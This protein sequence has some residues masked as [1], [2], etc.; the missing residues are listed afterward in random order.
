MNMTQLSSSRTYERL[1]QTG[2]PVNTPIDEVGYVTGIEEYGVFVRI[3][4]HGRFHPCCLT[5]KASSDS[6]WVFD[7]GAVS[8]AKSC[9]M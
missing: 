8:K 1:Y 2:D 5:P 3:P 7:H 6:L 9:V 4:I